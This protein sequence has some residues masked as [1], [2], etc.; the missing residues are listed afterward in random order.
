VRDGL[1]VPVGEEAVKFWIEVLSAD[2]SAVLRPMPVITGMTMP[3]LFKIIAGAAAGTYSGGKYGDLVTLYPTQDVYTESLQRIEASG[4]SA[5][6][7]LT[8]A[9]QY[10][11]GGGGATS[12]VGYADFGLVRADAVVRSGMP[13]AE[14]EYLVRVKGDD[15]VSSGNVLE[16]YHRGTLVYSEAWDTYNATANGKRYRYTL[17]G[18]E[19]RVT[20]DWQN[21]SSRPLWVF[22][23][24]APYPLKIYSRVKDAAYVEEA[25]IGGLSQPQ[26]VY[27]AAQIREDFN[28]APGDPLPASINFRIY[29]ESSVVG[30]GRELEVTL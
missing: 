24:Q 15:G 11:L 17:S 12:H 7:K 28:L 9:Q 14:I 21:S 18:S 30:R 27:S 10:L 26:T 2:K 3:L 6:A 5:E 25:T 16:L 20:R 22:E 4:P 1:P 19:V 23:Q 8:A 29:Q 13:L